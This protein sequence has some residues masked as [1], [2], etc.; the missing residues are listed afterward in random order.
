MSRDSGGRGSGVPSF[1]KKFVGLIRQI[2]QPVGGFSAPPRP[3]I[4]R[5]DTFIQKYLQG[6]VSRG[7]LGTAG[8]EWLNQTAV[9]LILSIVDHASL[10]AIVVSFRAQEVVRLA[11]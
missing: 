8:R 3:A 10:P 7:S 11:S 6:S 4:P 2:S 1:K 9:L 5:P